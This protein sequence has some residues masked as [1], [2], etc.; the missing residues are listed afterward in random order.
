M[1]HSRELGV[2]WGVNGSLRSLAVLAKMEGRSMSREEA[3]R[4][5]PEDDP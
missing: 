1:R 2:Q 5:T 3:V 4:Y